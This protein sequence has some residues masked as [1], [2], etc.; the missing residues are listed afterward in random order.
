MAVSGSTEKTVEQLEN[1]L[2][3][4]QL[5]LHWILQISK[6]INFDYPTGQLLGT[7]EFIL[8]EQLQI[9]RLVLFMLDDEWHCRVLIK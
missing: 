8:R 3:S 2:H 7:Y 1:D 4:R 5:Q 6:A 9:K